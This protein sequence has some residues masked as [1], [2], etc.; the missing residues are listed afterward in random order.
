MAESVQRLEAD[1]APWLVMPEAR[2]LFASLARA[3]GEA[4]FVGG[5]VRDACL[6]RPVAAADLDIVTTLT[7]ERVMAAVERAV[8]TG[9]VHGTVTVLEGA[10]RFEV[11]TLRRDIACDGR[12][13]EVAFTTD[14]RADAARRDFTVNA[15]S[16][17]MDGRLFDYFG[18]LDDLAAGRLRFVGDPATRIEEDYLRILRYFRFMPSLARVPAEG[19]VLT[20][21]RD[22]AS[23]LD[24]LSGE[25]IA[26][27][28]RKLLAHPAP[29]GALAS[30]ND[31]GVSQ[32]LFGRAFDLGPLR[33]L[34]TL[35]V[36][37]DW[38]S[39][40]VLL[41]R[42]AIDER[43]VA[44][45]LR[46]SSAETADLV[47]GCNNPLPPLGGTPAALRAF[48]WQAGPER[49]A[50]M[51]IVAV[52]LEGRDR[53]TLERA[54]SVFRAFGRPVLPVSGRDLLSQGMVEG[55]GIGRLLAAIEN[56]WIASDFSLSRA[57]L[58]DRTG[59][60]GDDAS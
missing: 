45:R 58:L 27:E 52:A 32:T 10:A 35:G 51:A 47:F 21:I 19:A 18:G 6:R 39:R 33:H 16:A 7:P 5:C 28:F 44:A 25:R 38:L 2:R 60:T 49:A 22:H 24:R 3:G 30:M 20:A 9:L 12:H 8:P 36:D 1:A 41:L 13:A 26:T 55:P 42:A 37:A 57:E 23:G 31:C 4:R 59:P 34:E 48:A 11:T 40:F 43:A 56:R 46:L 54:S 29:S 14:F 17:D 15:M 50:M 53:A